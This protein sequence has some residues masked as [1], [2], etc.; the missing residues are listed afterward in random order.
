VVRIGEASKQ[1]TDEPDV[2]SQQRAWAYPA[3]SCNSQGVIGFTAFYG[4]KDRNP[5]HVVGVR[6]ASSWSVVYSKLGS[7]SP[8][9]EKWGDYLTCRAH[10]PQ[11]DTWVAVGY[12]LEGGQTRSDVLPRLVHFGA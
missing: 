11:T 3:A 2:W 7:D 4:G 10:A 8:D 9:V 5:G 1:V 6:D 12:T